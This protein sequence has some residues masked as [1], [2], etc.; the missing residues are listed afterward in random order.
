MNNLN[1]AIAINGRLPDGG[2]KFVRLKYRLYEFV[3][4]RVRIEEDLTRSR[5]NEVEMVLIDGNGEGQSNVLCYLQQPKGDT[6]GPYEV[7]KPKPNTKAIVEDEDGWIETRN[8]KNN[9]KKT[10]GVKSL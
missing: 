2:S 5:L 3:D 7:V 10:Q 4:G 6:I 9:K 8:D 1:Y